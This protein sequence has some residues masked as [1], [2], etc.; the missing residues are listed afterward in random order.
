MGASFAAERLVQVPVSQVRQVDGPA[1]IHA[2]HDVAAQVHRGDV[3]VD[4]VN[5]NPKWKT[6]LNDVKE[7]RIQAIVDTRS[8]VIERTAHRFA[9]AQKD[10]VVHWRCQNLV[11]KKLR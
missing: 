10:K 1:A 11:K 5:T 6:P 9:I 3:Q 4:H 8:Q 7:I 2:V